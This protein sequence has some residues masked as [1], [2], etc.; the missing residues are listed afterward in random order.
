MV[1]VHSSLLI[2]HDKAL[3][4][5]SCIKHLLGTILFPSQLFAVFSKLH[6]LLGCFE[7]NSKT[8]STHPLLS[9]WVQRPSASYQSIFPGLHFKTNSSPPPTSSLFRNLCI[10]PSDSWFFSIWFFKA[11]CFISPERDGCFHTKSNE[12]LKHLRLWSEGTD[13]RCRC[14]CFA[15]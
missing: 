1:C 14:S 7:E 9:C 11:L 3:K 2:L 10:S 13:Q 12:N 15:Q 4:L 5:Y 6:I 8:S